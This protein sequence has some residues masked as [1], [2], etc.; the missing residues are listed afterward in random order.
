MDDH[1]GS[2][3]TLD[4]ELKIGTRLRCGNCGSELIVVTKGVAE[5]S[6]CGQALVPVEPPKR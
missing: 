5:L 3:S 1:G 4:G 6:C 2:P